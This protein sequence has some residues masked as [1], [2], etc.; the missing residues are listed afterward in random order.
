MQHSFTFK[1]SKIPLEVNFGKAFK[2]FPEYGLHIL[3]LLVD[4]NITKT[5]STILT[6]D[7]SM[8]KLWFYYVKDHHTE[9]FE[10]L[11]DDLE[12]PDFKSFKDT[13]WTA[14]VNF[15][16]P[17]LRPALIKGRE[18]VERQLA[19]TLKNLKLKEQSSDTVEEQE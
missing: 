10:N 1:G 12:A 6:D 19:K 16:D 7:L 5:L 2:V 17:Q 14:I 9:S 11:I 8:L 13:L 18:E 15:T 3:G 4:E